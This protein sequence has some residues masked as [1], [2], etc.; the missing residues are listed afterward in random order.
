MFKLQKK[1]EKHAIYQAP[2]AK[3]MKRQLQGGLP[4]ANTLMKFSSG[5]WISQKW[6]VKVGLHVF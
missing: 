6:M 3:G 2:I 4:A 1:N 5:V